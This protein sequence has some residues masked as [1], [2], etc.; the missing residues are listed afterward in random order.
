MKINDVV[1]MLKTVSSVAPL[2]DD[3]KFLVKYGNY[4]EV[5]ITIEGSGLTQRSLDDADWWDCECGIVNDGFWQ[6]CQFCKYPRRQ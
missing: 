1:R 3:N 6:A 4:Q 5:V 2:D